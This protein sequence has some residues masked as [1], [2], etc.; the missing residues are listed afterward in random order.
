M[1]VWSRTAEAGLPYCPLYGQGYRSLGCMPCT[2]LPGEGTGA[3]DG[4]GERAGRDPDKEA[5]MGLLRDLGY[6]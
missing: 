6:F 2:R 5:Q 3:G 4:Q 1:D